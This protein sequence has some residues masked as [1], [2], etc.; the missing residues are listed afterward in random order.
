MR[1]GL[2]LPQ[3]GP[4]GDPARVADFAQDAEQ[5]GYGSL[6][7]G[8]RILTPVAPSDPYP[9]VPQPYPPE[10]TRA[11]DP[12]VVW[13]AAAAATSRIR[14]GSSTLNA[15]WYNAVLLA[16]ALTTLDVLSGGRLDVGL[17]TSWSRDEYAAA[18][19][20]WSSRG[21]RLDETLDL[22]HAWWTTNPVEHHGEFFEVTRSV[23]DL[24]PVQPGGPPVLLGGFTPAAMRRVGRRSTGWLLLAGLPDDV[25]AG[26]W[27]TARRAAESAGRDPDALQRVVR[28]NPPPGSTADDLA[29]ELDGIATAGYDSAF[30]DLAFSTRSVDEALDVAARVIALRGAPTPAHRRDEPASPVAVREIP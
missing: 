9:A 11:G 24:R 26:L 6:W 21:R 2:A 29:R 5:L 30:V 1:L 4:T 19:V 27:G 8:D 13:A 15:P 16:R 3:Y 20:D 12:L 25:V 7:V 10:F 17:G 14:L 23:V 28:V 18:G 22:W